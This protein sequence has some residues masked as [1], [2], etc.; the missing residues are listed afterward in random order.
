M[1]RDQRPSRDHTWIHLGTSVCLNSK[2]FAHFS[3]LFS[4]RLFQVE[5]W[6][7]QMFNLNPFQAREAETLPISPHVLFFGRFVLFLHHQR[8]WHHLHVHGITDKRAESKLLVSQWL[9]LIG[10][11]TVRPASKSTVPLLCLFFLLSCVRC[12]FF[13]L[14]FYIYVYVFVFFCLSNN[15]FFQAAI[16]K[17]R[18]ASPDLLFFI[19]RFHLT[20]KL[21]FNFNYPTKSLLNWLQEK[22]IDSEDDLKSTFL[23]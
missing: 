15:F 21:T 11:W 16:V 9:S 23:V 19:F 8:T 6:F 5:R 7:D 14:L 12:A 13:S 3:T 20:L 2:G 1:T 10:S 17:A 18:T 22:S 4:L